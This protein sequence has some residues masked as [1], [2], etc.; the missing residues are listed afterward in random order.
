VFASGRVCASSDS[1]EPLFDVRRRSFRITSLWVFHSR[2]RR[3]MPFLMDH[4][5]S[6]PRQNSAGVARLRKFQRIRRRTM[7]ARAIPFK[8]ARGQMSRVITHVARVLVRFPWKDLN[9]PFREAIGSDFRHCRVHSSP[10]LF[11]SAISNPF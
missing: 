2:L 8:R 7:L 3:A 5:I 6:A 11:D 1:R 10:F 9:L 4:S